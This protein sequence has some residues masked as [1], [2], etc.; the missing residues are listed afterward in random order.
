[1]WVRVGLIAGRV[2]LRLLIRLAPFLAIAAAG[3]VRRYRWP[4]YYRAKAL[5]LDRFRLSAVPAVLLGSTGGLVIL[6]VAL[7][8]L[9]TLL[10]PR[11]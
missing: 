9:V 4:I 8:V 3:L 1:M 11:P 10:S 2:L 5:K 6:G 7:Y